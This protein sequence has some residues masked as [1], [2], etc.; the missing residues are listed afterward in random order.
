M[1]F[2]IDGILSCKNNVP[3]SFSPE[4]Q[5]GSPH[6]GQW[7]QINVSKV[8]FR[9]LL[10]LGDINKIEDPLIHAKTMKSLALVWTQLQ[11]VQEGMDASF[12]V[13]II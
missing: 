6:E 5:S 4:P 13:F 8:W 7:N 3:M 11:E 1:V 10:S 12:I 2:C 9:M